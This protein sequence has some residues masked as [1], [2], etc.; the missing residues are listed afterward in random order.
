LRLWNSRFSKTTYLLFI[1]YHLALP[2]EFIIIILLQKKKEK[3]KRKTHL[4]YL[5]YVLLMQLSIYSKHLALVGYVARC[6]D[7]ISLSSDI[8]REK[9]RERKREKEGEGQIGDR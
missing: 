8:I 3:K 2:R 7:I 4:I 1:I 9:E 5:D 6:N